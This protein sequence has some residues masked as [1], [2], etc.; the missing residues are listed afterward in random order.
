MIPAHLAWRE[1]AAFQPEKQIWNH[2]ESDLKPERYSIQS[3]AQHEFGACDRQ[4]KNRGD[5]KMRQFLKERLARNFWKDLHKPFSCASHTFSSMGVYLW[6]WVILWNRNRKT[7]IFAIKSRFSW[8]KH[9][10]LCTSI[11]R[12]FGELGYV[13]LFV[14]SVF[15]V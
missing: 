13:N 5:T 12:R 7:A 11:N 15:I 10:Y 1:S 14:T 9:T 6:V 4:K 8:P 3:P 2:W